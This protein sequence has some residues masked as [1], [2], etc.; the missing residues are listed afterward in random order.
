MRSGTIGG[1]KVVAVKG[2][3]KYEDL[4][5]VRYT[6]LSVRGVKQGA[7]FLY[8]TQEEASQKRDELLDI[9]QHHKGLYIGSKEKR[10]LKTSRRKPAK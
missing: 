6:R 3:E 1:M 4:W 5:V 10:K 8:E 7:V 9:V 2:V